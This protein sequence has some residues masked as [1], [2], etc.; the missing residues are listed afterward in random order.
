MISVLMV[1]YQKDN[2]AFF[3]RS[4]KS[5]YDDQVLKPGEVII[6]E[7]GPISP[8]HKII[9]DN[10]IKRAEVDVNRIILKTNL[11]LTKAL[12]IGLKKC[13]FEF[14]ARM[15]ADDISLPQRFK[16]QVEYLN[17]NKN[18]DILGTSIQ[19]FDNHGNLFSIRKFP[20]NHEDVISSIF[21]YSPLSHTTVMFRKSVFNKGIEY[22]E[23]YIT[24]QD[25]DLWF[26]A[27]FHGC[28]I[29]SLAEVLMHYRLDDNIHKRRSFSKSINE[30]KIY[31]FWIH[32]TN[33]ISYKLIYP[34]LRFFLRLMPTFITKLIYKSKLRES[35]NK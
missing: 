11:G 12:N 14:I 22:N 7:N 25:I 3:E 18:I 16:K 31:W 9:I 13:R 32:K 2:V 19:E 15:D 8:K 4:L 24:S 34:L 26:N 30:F 17:N 28:K 33:G 6:V 20:R 21:K 27:I 23:K 10:F 1:C 35:L 5:I 29:E